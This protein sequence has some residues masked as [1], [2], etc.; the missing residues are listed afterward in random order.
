VG[1]PKR[2]SALERTLAA[3]LRTAFPHVMRDPIEATNTMLVASV[4]DL[5]TKRLANAQLS[6]ELHATLTAAATH[7]GPA[8]T[9]GAVY[10]DDKA[11]VEWLVDTSIVHY[12][13]GN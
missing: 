3:T 4:D 7:L 13:A 8:L 1:H 12:A 11:P 6:P 9:G 10:T 2:E 5:S